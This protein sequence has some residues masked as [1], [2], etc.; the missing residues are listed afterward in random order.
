MVALNAASS[1]PIKSI[2]LGAAVGP[3]TQRDLKSSMGGLTNFD[4]NNRYTYY[5]QLDNSCPH[6]STSLDKLSLSLI[7]GMSYDGKKRAVNEFTTWA[8]KNN[9]QSQVATMSRLFC[10][11]GIYVA[12][13]L[14][15]TPETFK[16]QPLLMPNV[17][18]LPE[19]EVPGSTSARPDAN[20]LQP[21][22]T[23][24]VINEGDA[25]YQKVY[26]PE[27]IIYGVYKEWTCVQMDTRERKT[28]GMYGSPLIESVALSIKNWHDVVNGYV[29]FVYKYG[30][31]RYQ[32]NFTLLE[33]L[34]KQGI[35]TYDAAQAAIDTWMEDNKNL[36]ANEDIVGYG[37][38]V[39]PI[40][41]AGSLDVLKFKESLEV[42]IAL[43]LFQS[44]ISMGKTE[45][46]T[47]AAGYVSEADRMV[48]LEG[49]QSILIN[50][51]S[52]AVNKLQELAGKSTDSIEVRFEELSRPQLT[53]Q[54]VLEWRN[55]GLLSD[56]LAL[57]WAGF[58]LGGGDT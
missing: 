47:Y 44:P 8:K 9:F 52:D 43:G 33:E 37:M 3:V 50:I 41:A 4:T 17:T 42:D 56:D 31:G 11:D 28:W 46:S 14:G 49:L 21:P 40:D 15:R 18:L 20:I 57:K 48:G 13:M 58:P 51:V 55:S 29:N 5:Q 12:E 54:D 27:Q 25:N 22:V 45:G 34:V 24:F 30:N 35:L 16:L 1:T 39:S 38:Q 7:K 19:G 36:S 26:S 23:Q 32:Y 53:S 2:K 6:V 10:R